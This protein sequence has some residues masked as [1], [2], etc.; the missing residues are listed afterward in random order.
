MLYKRG[1]LWHYDFTIPGGDR[2]RGST[3]FRDKRK[4]QSEEERIRER[5]A[6]GTERPVPTL[7]EVT[8]KWFLARVK[9]RR[10]ERRTAEC[11]KV[12]VRLIGGDTPVNQVGAREIS[13]AIQA[14]RY[15]TTR[16]GRPP[17]N[18]TVN[19]ELIDMTLRPILRYAAKVLEEPV[20]AIPW[21]DLRQKEPK[22]RS[23]S[24]TAKELDAFRAA[25]PAWHR[26]VFDF[27][28]RYGVRLA[29]TFFPPDALDPLN[30]EVTVRIRK[31]GLPHVVEL[32][33]EDCAD[34]GRR[35]GRATAAGLDT[36]WFSEPEP[37]VLVAI[38]P[39]GFQAACERAL[40]KTGLTDV[41]P[42]HDWRHHAA[43][44]LLR[45]TGNVKLVQKLLGHESIISTARYAHVGRG[46]V[47]AALSHAA[48]D[49]AVKAA[50]T[51]PGDGLP[52]S[53]VTSSR[54]SGSG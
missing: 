30:M 12:M 39:R 41:R 3:G 29:E 22:G 46:D 24:F 47:R 38:K 6:V 28:T 26:P 36:V 5:V 40:T 8:A 10:S 51:L 11:I 7:N 9:G 53:I 49:A 4:A 14:R 32:T 42:V 16:H 17:A 34:I 54:S 45:S 18:A 35:A 33:A 50:R 23:R 37:N 31:N 15:E 48:G 1:D 13:E 52:A 2:Q 21:V 19:R 20:R 25:L 43:T 27:C 44:D